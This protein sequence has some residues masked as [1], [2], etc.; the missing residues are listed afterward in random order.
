MKDKKIFEKKIEEREYIDDKLGDVII[1]DVELDILKGIEKKYESVFVA[2]QGA[3][4]GDTAEYRFYLSS[5]GINVNCKIENTEFCVN[6]LKRK[7]DTIILNGSMNRIKDKER[8]VKSLYDNAN[9]ILSKENSLD[10]FKKN[11]I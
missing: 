1:L 5:N 2:G 10:G 7:Y 6:N 4:P 3:G 9:K 11:G 8:F